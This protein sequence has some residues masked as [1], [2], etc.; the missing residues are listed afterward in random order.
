MAARTEPR[1]LRCAGCVAIGAILLGCLIRIPADPDLWGHLQF[2]LTA[3]S[4]GRL[5]STDPYS[6]TVPGAVWVN[7]EW[8]AEAAFAAA[9][10]IGGAAGLML[11][12]AGLLSLAISAIGR[13]LVRR[14]VPTIGVVAIAA[15]GVTVFSEFY[16]IRPQ[17]FTY[18]CLALL[19]W[20]CDSY[21][22][23]QRGRLWAVPLL[24]GV[25][26]N[27]HGGFVAGLG[28]FGIY[29][30]EFCAHAWR[31]PD[32]L[33][34]FRFL[35]MIA[36]AAWLA[37]LVNPYG[38]EY[39]RFVLFAVTLPRPEIGEWQSMLQQ[40]VVVVACYASAVLV[41][42]W[43]WMRST[44]RGHW[45]ET[46][47]FVLSVYLAGRHGRHLPF[48]LVFGAAVLARRL[49]EYLILYHRKD[50]SRSRSDFPQAAL[51]AALLLIATT[52]SGVTR[53]IEGVQSARREGALYVVASDF[54]VQAVD[55]MIHNQID[56]NL[57]CGFGWGQ[58]GLFKLHPRC[59]VFC[60][61]RYETVY[62]DEVTRLV[63]GE[64]H[65]PADWQVRIGRYPTE[66][67]LAKVKDPFAD[68]A[69]AHGGFLEIY[70]DA[71]ARLLVRDIPRNAALV[72]RWR[73]GLLT[74]PAPVTGPQPFPA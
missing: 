41:P 19:L 39:W 57:D 52:I 43:F 34:E 42:A 1:G 72:K 29:W 61:G 21:R 73:S 38:I 16:R 10:R 48:L 58:Y 22:P 59:R 23:D 68:W 51:A 47:A 71:T 4:E 25:W 27:F 64:Q 56:G 46:S 28:I 14:A 15:F 17:M 32:R 7:H 60:D 6:Y 18:T 3:F 62:P 63:L 65:T 20:M 54:P 49:P 45:A 13:V 9:Y 37:T 44:R 8:L 53:F 11:L 69:V 66:L 26:A 31:R 55:F 74:S 5:A 2:G 35:A 36:C 30:L 67:I 12:R 40:N 50:P 33:R 70:R 24:I